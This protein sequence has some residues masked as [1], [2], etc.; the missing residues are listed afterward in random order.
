V[1]VGY[2]ADPAEVKAILL[3]IADK[4]EMVL[5]FPKAIVSFN[6]FGDSALIFQLYVYLAS[7]SNGLT[8]RSDLRF[9]ILARFKEAGIAIPYPQRDV[10]IRDWP[11]GGNAF[12]GASE[13][14]GGAKDG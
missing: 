10:T 9:A 8:V 3:D 5:K 12:A 6:D 4:H 2:D 14:E 11:K 13:D 1:G 7:I